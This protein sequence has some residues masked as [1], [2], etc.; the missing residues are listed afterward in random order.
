VLPSSCTIHQAVDLALAREA[1][2]AY[3]PILVQYP[4]DRLGLLE[5]H[6]L[7]VACTF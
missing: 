1:K 6:A 3:D 7:L 5:M 2:H 4:D